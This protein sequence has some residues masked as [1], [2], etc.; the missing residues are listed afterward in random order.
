MNTPLTIID[1]ARMANVS[2]TTVSR[3]INNDRTV[4]AKNREKVQKIL[5]EYNFVP[6]EAARA[7]K[8][9]KSR[10]IGI[11]TPFK[12][13]SFYDNEFFKEI[14]SGIRETLMD[15]DYDI[16]FSSG[17]GFE[18][19]AITK[20]IYKNH[21]EGLILLYSV[22][23][24]LNI[25]ILEK[26]KVPYVITGPY[27]DVSQKNVVCYNYD[28]IFNEIV[29]YFKDKNIDDISLFC[30]DL[31]VNLTIKYIESFKKALSENGISMRPDSI[32]TDLNEMTKVLIEL[33]QMEQA[34][35]LPKAIIAADLTI[36]RGIIDF[37][38]SKKLPL[39]VIFS[40]ENNWIND[41]MKISSIE[42]N[43]RNMGKIATDLLIKTI[44]DGNSKIQ[45]E[46]NYQKIIR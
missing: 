43:F 46:L 30:S 1:I 40:L 16:L 25:K 45:L 44:K 34:D 42:H 2:K 27:N 33:S 9:G 37:Y 11:I 20:F 38:N 14:F 35:A 31:G 29:T 32:R 26:K 39:P 28:R 4:T 23:D 19:D 13:P 36:T 12:M 21:V 22:Q 10:T 6:S 17:K 18:S 15:Y 5:D 3:V 41:F 7:L 8:T 24:D